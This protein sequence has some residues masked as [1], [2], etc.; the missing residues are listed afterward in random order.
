MPM[1]SFTEYKLLPNLL[2][3]TKCQTIRPERLKWNLHV[4]DLVHNYWEVRRSLETKILA[5]IPHFLGFSQIISLSKKPI[6]DMDEEIA[7]K[8][9]FSSYNEMVEWF[10]NKYKRRFG[11]LYLLDIPFQIIEFDW[12]H[13][14]I[15]E[16]QHY[17][18]EKIWELR[19]KHVKKNKKG[20]GYVFVEEPTLEVKIDKRP[21][22]Y[23]GGY[24]IPF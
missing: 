21:T 10:T 15:P 2:L 9:G 20:G 11:E 19:R 14:F 3:R 8:D 5:G 12:L 4:G 13:D 24:P 6:K 1:M 23:S 16:W 17:T 18:R 22:P 7:K